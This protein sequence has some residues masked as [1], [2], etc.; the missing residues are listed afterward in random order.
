MG[1]TEDSTFL[2]AKYK[3]EKHSALTLDAYND[4]TKNSSDKYNA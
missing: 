2:T 4:D 1:K 3:I